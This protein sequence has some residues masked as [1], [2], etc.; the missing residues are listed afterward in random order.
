MSEA[1]VQAL[2]LPVHNL[3]TLIKAEVS[4]GNTIPYV[5]YVEARLQIPSIQ[6]MNKDSLFMVSNNSPYMYRVP[7]QLGTLRIREAMKS[8]TQDELA[9][10][11]IAWKTA[12]FP[13]YLKKNATLKEPEFDLNKIKGHVRLTKSVT[14]AP[15]QTVHV[16]G[17]MGCDQHSKRVNVIVEPDPDREYE[18]VAPIHGYTLLKP[19]SSR[20]SIGQ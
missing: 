15:F 20:V 3:H 11:S 13:S 18:S 16:S 12:S 2:K 7:I 14:I 19:G 6:A 9:K 1:L 10:L 8:A 4:G 17:L 5:G